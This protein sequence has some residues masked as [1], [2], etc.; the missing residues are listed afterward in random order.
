MGLWVYDK[1][2]PVGTQ[3]LF[4]TLLFTD[5]EDE[6]IELQGPAPRQ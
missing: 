4:G 2:F 3:F 6:N 5:G 1:K